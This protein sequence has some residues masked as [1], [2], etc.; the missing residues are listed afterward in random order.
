MRRRA[1]SFELVLPPR[2]EA[3]PSGK[4]PGM[5]SLS[6]LSGIRAGMTGLG[7]KAA[8]LASLIERLESIG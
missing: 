2:P 4:D 7:A 3:V 5:P 8:R 6:H 1:S